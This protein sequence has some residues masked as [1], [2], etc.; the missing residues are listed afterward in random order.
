MKTRTLLSLM[1][2]CSVFISSCLVTSSAMAVDPDD[3]NN[4]TFRNRTGYDIVYLF[5]S[6]GDSGEWGTDILGSSTYFYDDEDR[7]FYIHYP[8]RC[9]NFDIM[10]I[11]EDD[12]AYILWDY[13][14]CDNSSETITFTLAD[15][16]DEAPDFNLVTVNLY[17][18]TD[19][20]MHYIFFSP[21]DSGMWGVDQLDDE[22]I[23][24]AYE[25]VSLLL[26]AEGKPTS[27]DIHAVDEDEDTY[28]F[29]VNIDTSRSEWTIPIELSDMD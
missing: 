15:L 26:P 10:A 12:D 5:L 13:E 23:L 18:D 28:T 21:G 17:N 20:D 16:N 11:D 7:G 27:Y 19:Y 29:S 2:S 8:D 25:T 3:L 1:L 9:N 22:T 24:G 6:P 4:I 14:I